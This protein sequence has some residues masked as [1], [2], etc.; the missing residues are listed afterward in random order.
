MKKVLVTGGAGYIGSAC[1]EYLLNHDYQVTVFDALITGHR[2]AVD[3]RA[4]FIEGNLENRDLIMDVC[5]QGKFDAV[6]HFAAFSLVGES[7]TDP[8]KYFRNNLANAINL[9][10]AAVAGGAQSFVFSSTAATFGQPE[11]VPISEND[12][13]IPINPYGE[14][15]LCFEKVLKWYSQIYGIKYAALRYFNAA[16]ATENYGE[17]HRPESHLIPIILQAIRGK[18]DKLMLF[19]DDY[20]TPD[21]SCIR[22]YIHILDL[23]QAHELALSAPESGHYNLGTGNGL[24]VFEIIKAAEKVTGKK[25]NFEIAPRRAGDPARLIACSDRARK[26]LNWTPQYESAEQIIESAWKWQL[27]HPE[28]YAK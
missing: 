7:M 18:R 24:S 16:G 13:Q 15:K 23:A 17:D 22:D 4:Q 6:M 3:P 21:G 20:D 28:G 8:S 27:K 14:S 5:K 10:D 1:T 2:D 12:R 26:M 11:R 19:G 9:A 25:V